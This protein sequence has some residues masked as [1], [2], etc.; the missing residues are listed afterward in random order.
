MIILEQPRKGELFIYRDEPQKVESFIPTEYKSNHA[1]SL[2]E[3]ENGDILC[4]WFAGTAEG[5]GDVRIIGSRL[6][7]GGEQWEACQVFSDEE[8]HSLQNPFLFQPPGGPLYLYHTSQETR[9]MAP[10][11]WRE[12]VGRGEARGTYVM[13]GTALIYRLISRDQGKTWESKEVFAGKRGSFCRHPIGILS[14]GDWIF[15]MYYSSEHE[16]PALSHGD[17]YSVVRISSDQGG[18]WTEYPV[19][20]SRGRVHMS[21]VHMNDTH[22]SILETEPG[23]CTAFFRSRTADFI[24]RSGSSDYGKTWTPPLPT[25]LPNN[26][27]SLHAIGLKSGLI[28]V[29]YNPWKK[30]IVDPKTGVRP[31]MRNSVSVA[32][33]EDGGETFPWIREVEP[34]DGFRGVQNISCNKD[35]AYPCILQSRDGNIHIAY[36]FL[37]RRC[38]KYIRVTEEWI[39]GTAKN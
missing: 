27:S 2:I 16:N 14:N 5:S 21:I 17:D 7:R 19:P 25:E 37:N 12:M 8:D 38:I 23:K 22:K 24:Y 10:E 11:K 4:A 3:L 33:S 39:K 30:D 18:T 31:K 20:E 28:A 9:G 35:H 26:N 34:G 13:Q 6:P 15:P 32:L 1:P 29:V 36:S